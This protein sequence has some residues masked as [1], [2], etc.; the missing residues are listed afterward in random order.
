M[1]YHITFK[2][3]YEGRTAHEVKESA[4]H[5]EEWELARSASA[6][7]DSTRR[8]ESRLRQQQS[9]DSYLS[10]LTPVHWVFF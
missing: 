5:L 8:Q 4:D 9:K 2:E 1:T 7:S 6:M 10:S 3:P